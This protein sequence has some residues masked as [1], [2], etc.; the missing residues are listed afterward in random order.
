MGR[1]RK[2]AGEVHPK[3]GKGRKREELDKGPILLP[4]LIPDR[5]APS[6]TA[7]G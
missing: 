4:G 7:S 2:P 3:D 6:W 5:S 1:E